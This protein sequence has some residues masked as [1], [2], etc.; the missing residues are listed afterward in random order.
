MTAQS[1]D[2]IASRKSAF[3]LF[4]KPPPLEVFATSAPR[5]PLCSGS[6]AQRTEVA[7]MRSLRQIFMRQQ[8]A[9]LSLWRNGFASDYFQG[10]KCGRRSGSSE[11]AGMLKQ[12]APQ[13]RAA[14][15]AHKRVLLGAFVQATG[16]HR[17]Y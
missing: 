6:F 14:S 16:Y 3:G 13:Y 12:F 4:T 9:L 7:I 11:Q 2:R 15:S 8:A 5:S 1:V 10:G 17:R